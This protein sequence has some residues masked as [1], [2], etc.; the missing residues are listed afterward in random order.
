MS[1]LKTRG[2]TL[3]YAAGVYDWCQEHVYLGRD[4]M[5]RARLLDLI[6]LSHCQRVLDLGC[7]TGNLTLDVARVLS[8]EAEAVGIDAAESMVAKAKAKA[9]GLPADFRVALAEDLPFGDGEFDAAV[10]SFFFHHLPADLKAKSLAEAFRVLRPGSRL[11]VVDLD[12]P[13]SL[14]GALVGYA[15][16]VLLVQ[17]PIHEN[18]QGVLPGLMHDAGFVDVQPRDHW[19]GLVSFFTAV[20][21]P[22]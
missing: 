13:T 15:S 22:R 19:Y 5:A 3:D 17:K 6:D 16:F 21:A 18:L 7:A 9:S 8:P 1:K 4:R 11:L 10:S 14:L 20:R 2:R 12:R